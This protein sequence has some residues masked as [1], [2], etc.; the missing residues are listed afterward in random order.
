MTNT[1]LIKELMEKRSAAWTGYRP[2]QS[3]EQRTNDIVLGISKAARECA[4][5]GLFVSSYVFEIPDREVRAL[6]CERLEKML[7][8]DVG[9]TAAEASCLFESDLSGAH[10]LGLVLVTF[11]A[12]PTKKSEAK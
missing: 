10:G 8:Y 2:P 12:L 1:V 4:D 6:F 9:Y 11:A 5:R 3:I 7:V